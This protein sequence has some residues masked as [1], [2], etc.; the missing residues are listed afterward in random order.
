MPSGQQPFRRPWGAAVPATYFLISFLYFGLRLF[1]H[2]GRDYIGSGLDPEIFIWSFG[3]W[4]HALVHG[5]NPF[6]SHAIWAPDGVNLAWITAIPGLALLFSPLTLAL[7]PV[8]AFN[9]ASISM[10]ALAAWTAYVL[11]RRVTD[12]IWAAFVGGYLFG[13]SSYMLG[14]Q[15]GHTNLT[16]VFL[17]PVVA[18]LVL[19]FLDGEL[20]GR[21][22]G[23]RLGVVVAA[24]LL[25]STEVA[26]S[27]AL[28][29]AAALVIALAMRA[30]QGVGRAFR[31]I[32]VGY[33]LGA[34]LAAPL[35]VYAVLGFRSGSVSAPQQ[36][37]AD[38]ANFVLPTPLT[39]WNTNHW[40]QL[41]SHFTGD[42]SEQGAYLG[43]PTLAII[44][45]FALAR[46]RSP[47]GRFLL[48]LLAVAAFC[49]LGTALYYE[50]RPKV[51][52]PWSQLATAPVFDNL[53]PARF[54][55]FVA[56]A[57]AVIV[58]AWLGI[59][60]IPPLIRVGLGALA[61]LAILPDLSIDLWSTHPP[62]PRFFSAGIYKRC[63]NAG[64]NVIVIPYNHHG[65]TMLWQAVSGF[66]FNTAGSYIAPKIPP[67]FAKFPAAL[68]L[69]YNVLPPHGA[70]D[71][72]DFAR[73]KRVTAILLDLGVRDR[74]SHLLAPFGPPSAA[75]G[76]LVYRLS[77]HT[78]PGCAD[79]RRDENLR[80]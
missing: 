3:W 53:L 66:W 47:A 6:V 1:P 25:F 22:L 60:R 42:I 7:G 78:P 10:P 11:C 77:G 30:R 74:W 44:C 33:V 26:F 37:N 17:I 49:S 5:E 64:D 63:L 38:L 79:P 19:R 69:N 29:L 39:Y 54:T 50:G 52:L 28:A 76:I 13:F 14:Q 73:A 9:V 2:P 16:A 41:A 72:I 80:S 27:T 32:V 36:W 18:L 43:V 12:S 61:V 21:E 35:L 20:T 57:A 46:G 51:T 62:L 55:V 70:K 48:V 24:Q 15:L 67:A 65:D 8:L 45:W 56:L 75:G 71:V 31:P 59:R 34:L 40:R 23:I 58:A 68:A 4:P